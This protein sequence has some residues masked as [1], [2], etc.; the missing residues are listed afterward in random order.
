M[1]A[2]ID[3]LTL[4][5]H[6]PGLRLGTIITLVLTTGLCVVWCRKYFGVD[7]VSARIFFWGG[8]L[9][10]VVALASLV[11]HIHSRWRLS[12]GPDVVQVERQ[13]VIRRRRWTSQRRLFR[14]GTVET[15]EEGNDF[16]HRFITLH[17]SDRTVRFMEGHGERELKTVRDRLV[18]W[19]VRENSA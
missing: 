8:A 7:A 18:D 19:T 11:D 4:E 15:A 3:T 2:K 10:G 16:A 1:E 13:G 5:S 6:G 17:L 14:I 12:I 9:I